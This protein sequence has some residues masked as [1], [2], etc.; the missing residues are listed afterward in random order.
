[1]EDIDKKIW[2]T[3]E[4]VNKTD[5]DTKITEGENKIPTITDLDTLCVVNTEVTDI[6][7][8]LPDIT[9]LATKA[10]LNVKAAETK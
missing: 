6:E 9:N 7:N 5:L 3:G 4:L 2:N 8:K 10:A 1:M